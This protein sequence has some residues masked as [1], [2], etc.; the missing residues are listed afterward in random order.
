MGFRLIGNWLQYDEISRF[1]ES[2]IIAYCIYDNKDSSML[3]IADAKGFHVLDRSLSVVIFFSCLGVD[4]I[5]VSGNFVY[6]VAVNDHT[7]IYVWDGK[8]IREIWIEEFNS[9]NISYIKSNND[10]YILLTTD[11]DEGI[12]TYRLIKCNEHNHCNVGY[13]FELDVGNTELFAY[14]DQ[15]YL[16]HENS[17]IWPIDIQHLKIKDPLTSDTINDHFPKPFNYMPSW[18]R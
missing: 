13:E 5:E 3:I 7:Y 18:L 1:W 15:V 6:M 17:N 11:D 9:D 4:M 14:N 16:Y 10:I 2:S 12:A 8:E